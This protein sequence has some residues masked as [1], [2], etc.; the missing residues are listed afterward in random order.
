MDKDFFTGKD[1]ILSVIALLTAIVNIAAVIFNTRRLEKFK[2]GL[3]VKTVRLNRLWDLRKELSTFSTEGNPDDILQN[4]NDHDFQDKLNKYIQSLI[5]MYKKVLNLYLV[6]KSFFNVAYQTEIETNIHNYDS[7]QRRK[8]ELIMH[9]KSDVNFDNNKR[10]IDAEIISTADE[11]I[12]LIV[13]KL[14]D[15]I[16]ELEKEFL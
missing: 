16:T 9:K 6:H 11:G 4:S 5:S 14:H 12:K 15:Q 2:K 8:T 1:F 3:D 7:L 13:N 10:E